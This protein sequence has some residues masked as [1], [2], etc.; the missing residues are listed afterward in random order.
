M[1]FIRVWY[2]FPNFVRSI[3]R[4]GVYAYCLAL[5]ARLADTAL[6]AAAEF[7]RVLKHAAKDS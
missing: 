1:Q 2:F 5:G 4:A 6:T 3:W 7:L